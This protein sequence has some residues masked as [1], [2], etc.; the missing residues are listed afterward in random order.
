MDYNNQEPGWEDKYRVPPTEQQQQYQQPG[1]P[2]PPQDSRVVLR[3]VGQQKDSKM[4]TAALVLGILTLVLFW[5]PI[6]SVITGL[7]GMILAII[8][9][10]KEDHKVMAIIGMILS[11][12]GLALAALM[13]IGVVFAYLATPYY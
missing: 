12:I 4:A 5:I 13:I 11:I 9:L 1:G 3:E 7:V 2:Y 10:V 6:L 8:S